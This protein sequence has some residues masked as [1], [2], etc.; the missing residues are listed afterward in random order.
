M[1]EQVYLI[2]RSLL[3]PELKPSIAQMAKC[4]LIEENRLTIIF[5]EL[6]HLG[7]IERSDTES[8]RPCSS[9]ITDELRQFIQTQ[10]ERAFIR[11]RLKSFKCDAAGR[12]QW[13]EQAHDMI[14]HAK[15]PQ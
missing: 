1:G 15:N 7:L 9:V 10:A 6:H 13:L 12:L 2:L 8:W 11:Q 4:G 14:Q 5:E 3:Y